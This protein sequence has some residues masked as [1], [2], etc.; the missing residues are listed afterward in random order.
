VLAIRQEDGTF[1]TNPAPE[2]VLTGGSTLIAI[3][4]ASQLEDLRSLTST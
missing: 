4:T 3:G 2:T 1:A